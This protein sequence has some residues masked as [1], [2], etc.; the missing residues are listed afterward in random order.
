MEQRVVTTHR[1]YQ[2]QLRHLMMNKSFFK[3]M[4]NVPA[5]AYLAVVGGTLILISLAID[6]SYGKRLQAFLIASLYH[7][8]CKFQPT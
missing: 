3:S 1:C 7:L 2:S 6:F 5:Q 8:G 4:R